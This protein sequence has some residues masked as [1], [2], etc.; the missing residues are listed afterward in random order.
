VSTITVSTITVPPGT[1]QPAPTTTVPQPI[2]APS[3]SAVP[4]ADLV[5]AKQA[6]VTFVD[7]LGRGDIEAAAAVVG[8]IS[9]QHAG[10][11]A[12]LRSLLQES[13]EGHGAWL[14]ATD[15]VVTPI[16]IAP[17]IAVVVLEATLRVEGSIEHR[18]AAYPVRKAESADAWLVEP[19]AYVCGAAPPLPIPSPR[20]DA[21]SWADPAPGARNEIEVRATA[22]GTVWASFDAA[23]PATAGSLRTAPRRSTPPRRPR[24]G[25]WCCSSRARRCTRPA[26]G[27]ATV[28]IPPRAQPIEPV[29]DREVRTSPMYQRSRVGC[30]PTWRLAR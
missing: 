6:T 20:V 27:T 7:S 25:R 4:A 30:E 9:E 19:W 2:T 24:S 21:E 26:T 16:G 29:P 14:G 11:A 15:H 8:P 23:A 17:G 10:N 12:G 1:T 18:V 3:P 5:R 22:A 13:T 28:R